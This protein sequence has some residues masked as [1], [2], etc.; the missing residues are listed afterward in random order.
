MPGGVDVCK[1]VVALHDLGVAVFRAEDLRVVFGGGRAADDMVSTLVAGGVL[2]VACEAV[3]VFVL[4]EGSSGDL[5]CELA[6]AI[7]RGEWIYESFASAAS[8][9]GLISQCVTSLTLATSGESRVCMTPYGMIEYVHL[10]DAA[11]TSVDASMVVDRPALGIPLATREVTRRDCRL[12]G[13]V[14]DLIDE[15]DCRGQD[16]YR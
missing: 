4:A 6:R 3:Y 2:R 11:R 8:A 7:A 16:G 14:C 15:E 12:A 1:A 5:L 9:H 10:D 13:V